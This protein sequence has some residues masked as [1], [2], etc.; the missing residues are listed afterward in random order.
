[1]SPWLFNVYM[2]AV[3]K[4]VKIG[5]GRRGDCLASFIKVIWFCMVSWRKTYRQWRD[6]SLRC[7]GGKG[8]KVNAG[9]SKVM[10]LG[11]EKG[12]KCDVCKDRMRLEHVSEFKY[13]E[14]VLD[15]GTDKAECH[16][17]VASRRRVAGAFRSL[18]NGRGLQLECARVLHEALLMPVLMYSSG[19]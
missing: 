12:L 16:R 1:M 17:K 14:C 7:V 4:K 19:Q 2:D 15:E 9:K 10:V 13:L 11:G 6:V 8:L 3:M 5:M 18:V